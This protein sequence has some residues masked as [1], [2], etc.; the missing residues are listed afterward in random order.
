MS[1][2][3]A[4]FIAPHLDDAVYSCGGTIQH[5]ANS[6]KT[7]A[8]VTV[9][10]GLPPHGELSDFA[11]SLHERWGNADPSAR[12]DLVK[13]RQQEDIEAAWAIGAG[14]VH[15]EYPDCIY[16]TDAAGNWLYASEDAIFGTVAESEAD[17]VQALIENIFL[18]DGV[19]EVT[20]LYA[21]LGIG[22]HVDHQLVHQAM[23]Q[24]E[25]TLFYEDYPYAE[26][27]KALIPFIRSY[28][29]QPLY[30]TLSE[31]EIHAKADAMA[32]Y[33]SQLT[34]FWTDKAHL[35]KNVTAYWQRRGNAER[36][37]KFVGDVAV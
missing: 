28:D 34:T 18:L 27:D 1:R 7:V 32:A 30:V 37:W 11:Q 15:L 23:I 12:G 4:L 14:T 2:I 36:F 31:A 20:Q 16:R 10:A 26:K 25:G 21:P 6:G 17:L 24:C 19:D 5:L 8:I 9:F 3:D 13:A 22:K 29:W 33:K 35:T